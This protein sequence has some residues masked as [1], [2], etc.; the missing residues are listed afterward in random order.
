[1][2]PMSTDIHV[3]SNLLKIF[4]PIGKFGTKNTVSKYSYHLDISGVI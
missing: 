1:M 3:S 2:T 4:S